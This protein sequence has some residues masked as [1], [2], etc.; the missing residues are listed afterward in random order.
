MKFPSRSKLAR[1]GLAAAVILAGLML[2]GWLGII[3]ALPPVETASDASPRLL[4]REGEIL[5]TELS[6]SGQWLWPEK[7]DQMGPHL[8]RLAAAVEDKRFYRHPG[9]DPLALLRALGQNILSGRIVSGG[10]TI[11][12]QTVKLLNPSP[13][14]LVAKGR[15]FASALKLES[16]LSKDEILELYLN[17]A[18]MGGNIQGVGA[19]S[20]AYYG[21]RPNELSLGESLTLIAVLRKPSQ[22]RP[23]RFPEKARRRRDLLLERLFAKGAITRRE[24]DLAL[25]EP[26]IP[27]RRAFPRRI[28]HLARRILNEQPRSWKTGSPDSAGLRTAVSD[29]LQKLMVQ[30]LGQALEPFPQAVTGAGV[31]LDSRTGEVLAYTGNAR[32]EEAGGW[33]DLALARRSPGSA[34]KPFI[35]LAAFNQGWLTPASMLAD[36]PWGLSGQAPRNFDEKYRGPVTASYALAQ[37][38]NVPAVRVLRRLGPEAAAE[39]LR[40]AGFR[41]D[42]GRDYGDSLVLG[43]AEVTLEELVSAYGALARQGRKVTPHFLA[44]ETDQAEAPVIFPAEASWMVNQILTEPSRRPRG[45]GGRGLAFKTGTS[46]GFRDA[47]LAVYSPEHTLV[48]WLEIG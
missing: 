12:V 1:T 3:L 20:W 2:G 45:L 32:P 47:W 17:L 41:T 14:T 21:K 24:R 9:V 30:R 5:Y 16:Q 35:Y 28:P 10:S 37:S 19:A 48:M 4:S 7:L 25:A 13:R 34:L 36:T 26:V 46:P 38:L 42:P 8:P 39:V 33:L 44:G 43:G 40:Q 27:G 22:Y 15:E 11:T 6:A 18:P 29:R 31:L 23:D